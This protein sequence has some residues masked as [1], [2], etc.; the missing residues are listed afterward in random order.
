M[1][2]SEVTKRRF[3]CAAR[4]NTAFHLQPVKTTRLLTNGGK[5][6]DVSVRD[7]PCRHIEETLLSQKNHESAQLDEI[8]GI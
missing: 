8:K 2:T 5:K 7:N 3:R 1:A 6:G 4:V